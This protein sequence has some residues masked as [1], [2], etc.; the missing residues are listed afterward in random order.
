MDK[1]KYPKR[2]IKCVMPHGFLPFNA[3][4]IN[5]EQNDI[6]AVGNSLFN[7]PFIKQLCEIHN[8]HNTKYK[9][10]NNLLQN[11]KNIIIYTGGVREAFMKRGLYIKR[12]KGLFKLAKKHNVP[13]IPIYTFGMNDL[14]DNY[15]YLYY[16]KGYTFIPKKVKLLTIIGK[17]I[18]NNNNI[19]TF[20][21][22]YINEIKRIYYKYRE[23]Y[24]TNRELIIK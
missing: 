3:P 22:N 17:P 15:S 21:K 13:L 10:I 16:G 8:L 9:T 24:G 7:L 19:N 23:L 14:Y 18:Q 4:I 12:R 11:G 20:R 5:I 1:T 2:Y 6:F